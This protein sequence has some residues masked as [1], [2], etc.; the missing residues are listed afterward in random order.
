MTSVL[1]LGGTGWLSGWLARDWI[2]A[3]AEVTCLA[4]GTRPAPDG[5]A[6]VEADRAAPDAYDGVMDRDWDEVVDI[7]SDARH[8]E[9]AV[10]ALADRAAHWTYVSTLSVYAA[11]DVEGAD[12]SAAL[13]EPARPGD[14]YDYGRAKVAAEASV[15]AALEPRAAIVRPGLIVGPGDPSDR[16]GYWVARFAMAGDE[17][18]LV[19]Q[20]GGR[21]VQVIDV[22]DLAAFLVS[23]G[24]T[25]WAGI[26]NAI[27]DPMPLG[28]LLEHARTVAGHTGEV[29]SADD[30]LL[31]EHDVAYWMGP[32]AL[33]LWLP[34]DM[35]GFATRTNSVY[36]NLGGSLRPLDRTL[37]DTLADERERGLDRERRSGLPR[38]DELAVLA[39]LG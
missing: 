11:V 26:A 32:R 14:E 5:A 23:V 4:R 6:L 38:T 17:P 39:D 30:A 8:V 21:S 16:F 31:Q 10:S 28:D 34:A 27:G 7:S 36:R 1:V 29:R 35:N 20:T 37:R 12:E 24:R 18:V 22:R 25:G 13:L 9:A 19:P 3:G 15:R 33:P 2:A